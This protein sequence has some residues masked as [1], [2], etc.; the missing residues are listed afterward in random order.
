MAL[1]PGGGA[2][3][4]YSTPNLNEAEPADHIEDGRSLTDDDFYDATDYWAHKNEISLE[5]C[6][7]EAK[8]AMDLFLNNDFEQA[9]QKMKPLADKTMYHALG[10][11]TILFLQAMM[12]CDRADMEKALEASQKAVNV[13]HR[14]RAQYSISDSIFRLSGHYKKLS[15]E[16]IH[17]ELCYAEA[18]LFR[19][20]LTFFY[21]E[22]LASFI[23]GALKIRSC[24]MSYREC[25]RILNSHTWKTHNSKIRDEF[26]AGV[27][28]GLGSFNIGL[29]ILPG[30]ILKLLQVIGFN[31]KRSYGMKCLNK[32]AEMKHTLRSTMAS[33]SLLVWELFV[34]FFIGEGLPNRTL[35]AALFK[36]LNVQY[37][38]GAII[39]FLR[40][41]FH[42]TSG[43][44]DNAIYFYNQSVYCQSYYK[45]F[46][47]ICYWELQFAYA[48]LGCWDW[49][50]NYAKRLKNESRWS[51]CVYAY[52]IAIY[53]YPYDQS[54]EN[55]VTWRLLC[56]KVPK[57][58]L[59]IAG[60]SIPVEKFCERKAKRFLAEN[61]MY[62]ANFEFMYFWNI[63]S[64][65]EA[66]RSHVSDVM[67]KIE[68]FK[69]EN[70]TE[71]VNDLALYDFLR[72]VCLKTMRQYESA[73]R[74]L[75]KVIQSESRLTDNFYLVPNAT[76]ELSQIRFEQKNYSEAESLLN[77]VKQYKGYSLENK[78]LFRVH[79]A[80]ERLAALKST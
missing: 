35:C 75:Y 55:Y 74:C 33:L 50:A 43:D 32:V 23:K 46:H 40:A 44:V 17:A 51:R 69:R 30:K 14:F 41:R 31:G 76:F 52:L 54:I 4:A 1:Y 66:R 71:D 67:Y 13:I 72:G 15:D 80:V 7:A 25:Y 58:R 11:S 56:Q 73:E 59:R 78:L 21:D 6:I 63:F 18:L 47:H 9:Q 60:K 77:K 68:Q 70:P 53:I 27:L 22:S 64:I 42:L 12:T 39:L 48:M 5:Q 29:S 28:L 19:A 24:F 34:T 61:R 38:N 65:F 20:A 49:A 45:Q 16:E 3:L 36:D 8:A 57:V 2:H 37:P 26:E 79:A 10:Y 62:L